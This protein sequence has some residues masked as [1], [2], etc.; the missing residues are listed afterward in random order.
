[1]WGSVGDSNFLDGPFST[2]STPTEST[3]LFEDAC[4]DLQDTHNSTKFKYRVFILIR[5][6][7]VLIR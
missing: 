1:M 6:A 7:Q 2:M 5:V 3:V 4:R